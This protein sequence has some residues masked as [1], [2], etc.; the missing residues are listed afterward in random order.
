[1]AVSVGTG[2]VLGVAG[3]TASHADSNERA[4]HLHLEYV[5]GFE[6]TRVR[7]TNDGTTETRSRYMRNV[8]DFMCDAIARAPGAGVTGVTGPIG[9]GG[10]NAPG[11]VSSSD[12]TA[13]AAAT[14]PTVG[15]RERYGVPDAPPYSTYE[16]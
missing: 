6:G 12:Q 4:I 3:G 8:L 2:D 15:D 13:V 11:A 9:Y 1:G 7:E 5:T 14:Q 16:G 10:S